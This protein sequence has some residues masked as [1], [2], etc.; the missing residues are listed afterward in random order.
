MNETLVNPSKKQWIILVL[1]TIAATA[2]L[3]F[4][5][6]HSTQADYIMELYD[7]NYTQLSSLNSSYAIACGVGVIIVGML[8]GKWGYKQFTV[9]GIFIMIVAQIAFTFAPSYPVLLIAK[10]VSGFGNGCIYNAIYTFSILWFQGT[11]KVGVAAGAMTSADGIGT[12][13]GLYVFALMVTAWGYA[14]GVLVGSAVYGI[15]LII[16]LFFLKNPPVDEEESKINADVTPS[17]VKQYTNIF[18]RNTICHSLVVT[19]VIGGLGIANFWG[20][21]ILI[22]QG[23]SASNAGLCSS[24]FTAMGIVSSFLFGAISDKKGRQKPFILI[25]G[26]GMVAAYLLMLVSDMMGSSALLVF[27]LMVCGFCGYIAYPIGFSMISD[28]VRVD[29]VAK[30]NGIVQGVSYLVGML[31]FQQVMGIIKDATGTYWMGLLACAI[32]TFLLNVIPVIVLAKEKRD[33]QVN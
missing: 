33:L 12:F 29:M 19:G 10:F 20:P 32:F 25:G 4:Q 21:T 14:E 1:A 24:M 23:I 18:N 30:C 3:F 26:I 13:I 27:S 16:M 31:V 7:L 22:D 15:V 5:F 11:N 17:G 8:A 9:L 2:P 6:C 28:T